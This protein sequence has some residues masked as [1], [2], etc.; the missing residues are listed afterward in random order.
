MG[1]VL[2]IDKKNSFVAYFVKNNSTKTYTE[3]SK[4]YSKHIMG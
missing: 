2:C 4:R 3:V 1:F